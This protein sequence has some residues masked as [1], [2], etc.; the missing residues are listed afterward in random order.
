[1]IMIPVW[2]WRRLHL[3]ERRSIRRIFRFRSKIRSRSFDK[4]PIR[5]NV[6]RNLG[7]WRS[8]FRGWLKINKN[9]AGLAKKMSIY[10]AIAFEIINLKSSLAF[11][12]SWSTTTN[13]SGTEWFNANYLHISLE[14]QVVREINI[15]FIF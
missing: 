2:R 9:V 3:Q 1:M 8:S 7:R 15:L 4:V 13:D 12:V 11:F 14:F 5:R 10:F 6:N